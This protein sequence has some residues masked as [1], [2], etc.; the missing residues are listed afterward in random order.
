MRLSGGGWMSAYIFICD[1]DRKKEREREMIEEKERETE[2][3]REKTKVPEVVLIDG[4]GWRE[5]D[6]R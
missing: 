5:C 4:M 3:G 1:G 2:R 6:V